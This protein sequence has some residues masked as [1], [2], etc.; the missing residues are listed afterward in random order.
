MSSESSKP[1][2]P[3]PSPLSSGTD[4]GGYGQPGKVSSLQDISRR[5]RLDSAYDID[6]I[7]IPYSIA[8]TTRVEKLQYK[9]ILT[10]KWR[11]IEPDEPPPEN[12]PLADEDDEDVEAVSDDHVAARHLKCELEE[13]K[14][15]TGYKQMMHGRS[16]L[17]SI[18]G[19]GRA[20]SSG[21]NTPDPMSPHQSDTYSHD[22]WM[23]GW[24][25]PVASPPP[26]VVQM[27]E[28]G[29]ALPFI[30]PERRRTIS[31]RLSEDDR[32]SLHEETPAQ[33]PYE[34]RTFPLSD[35]EYEEM[36]R[37][38]LHLEHRNRSA[39]PCG[40]TS[41]G[42]SVPEDDDPADPEWT[43]VTEDGSSQKQSL[44]LKLAKR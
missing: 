15:F 23:G 8:A 21:A 27:E 4:M 19:D 37:V 11:L 2:S 41:S 29:T 34:H 43:V 3:V 16:R 6:N 9:E 18:R 28:Q 33:P 5:K 20:D 35:E 40:S 25:S 14:R 44:V 36:R 42:C 10:P 1:G 31:K 13:K 38:S 17:R 32:S 39:S 7:V 12:E 30:R 26:V 24:N 22:S